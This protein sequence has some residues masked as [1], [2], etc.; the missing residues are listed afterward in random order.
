M[1]LTQAA[2]DAVLASAESRAAMALRHAPLTP[3]ED[4]RMPGMTGLAIGDW[5]DR[6]AAFAPQ[7]AY[8]DR[9]AATRPDIVIA[10]EGCAGAGALL[11]FVADVLGRHDPGY[12]VTADAITRPDGVRVPLDA[13]RP[14]ATLARL[15]QEDFLILRKPPGGEEHVLIGAALLF[16]S[17]WSLAEKMNKPLV[18][19][20]QRVPAYDERLAP[21][22]QRLFDALREDRPLVRANWLVHSTDELHQPKHF[23]SEVKPHE[24]TGRFWLRVERQCIL[25]IP[26]ADGAVFTVKTLLTPIEGLSPDQR[27]GLIDALA[28]QAPAMR[29]YHGGAEHADAAV[30]ALKA[31]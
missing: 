5:L 9:L 10:G 7:M 4:E 22:V 12:D 14:F 29:D 20:H 18:G 27:Q 28:D 25:K 31:L 6:D 21:R 8:R 13:G 23:D 15:A 2:P 17:R 19:I 24:P 1:T 26:G 30:A 16:P 11:A 3:Y